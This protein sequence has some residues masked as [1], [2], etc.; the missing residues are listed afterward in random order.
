MGNRAAK[1]AL[2]DEFARVGKVL[3]SGRRIELLDV[4]ANGERTVE[5]LARQ[6][7][8]SVANTSQH[9]QVL[10]QAGLVATRREGTSVHYR[11]AAPEVFELWR[12]LRTLASS[13]LAEVERL[14]A[15][16]LGAR[17]QLEPIT[18][19]ELARRLEEGDELVVLD[20]R[21]TEEH[22]AG[23]L[24]GAVSIPLAELR[25]RLRELPGDREI[26]A[27]CRGPFCAFA[28]EAIAVLTDAGLTARRLEDGLPEW[29]AAGLAV[30]RS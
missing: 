20:V 22:A 7:G 3:A 28:H 9:L 26:V 4:L 6:L 24:P 14:A 16:Y 11:L 19:Q 12:A 1:Q 15:A 2:F 30:T 10:R 21:P 18:R 17:D 29:A 13:R 25:E 5:A 27:Y 23:H 8:L